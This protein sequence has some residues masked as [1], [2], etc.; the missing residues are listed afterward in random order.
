VQGALEAMRS[1]SPDL[2]VTDIFLGSSSGF[3]LIAA[4]HSDFP[5]APPIIACSG[6]PE[7]HREALSRGADLFLP[8]PVDFETFG[9][10]VA[11]LLADR[12][13][14]LAL[15]EEN[16]KRSRALRV[17]QMKAAREVFV[18]LAP[19]RQILE[20]RAERDVRW[21]AA[22]IGVRGVIMSLLRV[23]HLSVA[24]SSDPQR[25]PK[26]HDIEKELPLCRWSRTSAP[27]TM[28]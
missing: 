3:D 12:A 10:A 25:W 14:S 5:A 4:V 26:H 20:R 9:Q 7:V 15:L 24:V 13:P 27:V 8:K 28:A 18:A 16:A 21:A 22:F 23:D 17:H 19:V 11:A 2:I 1:H 6:M